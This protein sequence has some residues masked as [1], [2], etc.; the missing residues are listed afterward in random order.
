MAHVERRGPGRWRARYRDPAGKERSRTFPRKS[1]ADRFLVTVEASKLQGRWVDPAGARTPFGGYAEQWLSIQVF[2]DTTRQKVEGHLR[3]H[4]LPFFGHRPIGAI[5]PSEVQ[6]W[7]RG[8]SEALAPAT[9]EV[10][11]RYLAAIFLA[12]VRDRLIGETPCR[13]IALP[14]KEERRERPLT[15]EQVMRLIDALPARSRLGGVLG[16]GAGLRQGEAHGLL[17]P[18]VDFLRGVVH[19]RLQLVTVT[20]RPP[21]LRRPKSRASVRS[22][23][24]DRWVTDAIAAHIAQF[25][26]ISVPDEHGHM[27]EGLIIST[28]SGKPVSRQR[29]TEA[30]AHAATAVGVK[31]ARGPG[32]EGRRRKAANED[33]HA[34][35]AYWVSVLIAA[36]VS[37]KA[38]M[39]WAGHASISETFDV[40]GH[41]FPED[42]D[43]ARQAVAVRVAAWPRPE[44]AQEGS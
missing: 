10:M 37:P 34:L 40:Y 38:I 8:R 31:P 21:Y 36:G 43:L 15:D 26:T 14:E 23:P 29:W 5:R 44:Q 3:K 16:A 24:V 42:E 9:V 17:V 18:N 25:G 35:R 39:R 4:L 12:A 11:Y 33:G 7:V 30:W 13:G 22:V 2:R 19:V 41:L 27:V 28:A 6:A 1:D 20:G 32:Q